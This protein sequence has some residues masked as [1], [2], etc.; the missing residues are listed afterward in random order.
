MADGTARSAPEVRAVEVVG[1]FAG[2]WDTGWPAKDG[3]VIGF[4]DIYLAFSTAAETGELK[5]ATAGL[6]IFRDYQ[7]VAEFL[8]SCDVVYANC[9]PWAAL[10]HLV[11]AREELNVRIIREVRT[12][13]WVGYIWQEAVASRLQ[14]PGDQRIFPSRYSRDIW[15]CALPEASPARIYYPMIRGNSQQT[16]RTTPSR[17]TAGFFSALSHDKGFSSLPDVMSRMRDAGHRIDRLVLA[18]RQ[19][20]PD[21][22]TKVVNG[23]SEIGIDVQYHGGLPNDSAR[24]LMATCDCIFFLTTSSIESLGR[25]MVEASAQR[26]PVVTADFGAAV[27]LVSAEFRIPVDYPTEATGR[28]DTS[29][30]MARLAVERWKPPRIFTADACYLPAVGEYLADAQPTADILNPPHPPQL[31][32]PRPVRFSFE[33]EVDALRLADKLLD[34]LDSLHNKPIHELVDL[35][36]A[37]KQYLLTNGYN[38]RVS[39]TATA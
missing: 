21:L 33:C 27:D 29:F 36:G 20:D 28:S 38:P 15:D 25:V 24:E 31:A 19:A 13:G 3:A 11:R 12:V 37:L 39:F 9:G 7:R 10:L 26:V 8:A 34:E 30:P 17:G 1:V 5:L 18:G 4:E 14:R 6:D 32:N 23:L 22:Y 2:P 16:V 35:G